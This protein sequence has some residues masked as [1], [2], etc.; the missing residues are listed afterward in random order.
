M[1]PFGK[2]NASAGTLTNPLQYTGREF[3]QET[4]LNYYRAR[5]YDPSAGRFLSEDPIGFNG[6]IDFYAY[7]A[8]N[9]VIFTDPSRLRHTPGGPW[10]PARR[11]HRLGELRDREGPGRPRPP[12]AL[13]LADLVGEVEATGYTAAV[14]LPAAG[15]L[16]RRSVRTRAA[17]SRGATAA[18]S[19]RQRLL[20]SAVLTV[21]VVLLSMVP[22]LQFNNWQWLALALASPVVVWG[23]WPFHRAALAERPPRRRH[24]GH[25][26]LGRRRSPRTSGRCGRCSSATPAMPGHAMRSAC[27][28]RPAAAA[29][30]IYLEVAAAVTVVHPRRALLR[31]A[32]Q[33]ARPVPR[34]ARCSTRRQGRRRPA[35]R[36]AESAHSRS[37]ELAVGD[38]FVVRP[39]EKV[40]TDGVVV[41]GT[42]AVDASMLTGESVPVEVA[43][44][45]QRH[46]RHRQ[47]RRPARRAGDPGRRR[48]PLAQM[49]RLVED[50][51]NGKAPVQ[52][53]ADRISA[54]FVPVVHRSG[55][56]D[57]GGWLARP[58]QPP[59]PP[60]PPPSRC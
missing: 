56:A 52:R 60:S 15:Q 31:G 8:N 46:R 20:V 53:L 43:P 58:A 24:H 7:V 23:A 25:P 16:R 39:G 45:R 57:P 35:R 26:D 55:A 14:P 18:D 17:R 11:G 37:D 50:A 10:H 29:D 21:P 6:G 27:C 51:Q 2:L 4:G 28:P 47:R 32:R 9:P 19:L 40:A 42:S 33:A 54:V 5:Y 36:P 3:D 59:P 22:A 13:A 49:A 44:G 34:C 41:D 12:A 38:L 48:H 30:S 1:T